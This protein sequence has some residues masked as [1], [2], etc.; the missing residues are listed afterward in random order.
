MDREAVDRIRASFESIAPRAPAV[1]KDFYRRLFEA[2]PDTKGLFPQDMARLE[3]HL[4]ASLATIAK[5]IDHLDVL[6]EPLM[7]LGA[8]H[9]RFGARPEHYPV[10]RDCLI[11]SLRECSGSAWSAELDK[12]WFVA[13]NRVCEAMLRG[14]LRAANQAAHSPGTINIRPQGPRNATSP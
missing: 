6:E 1:V 2:R 3:G 10:V 7:Q 11:A 14:V 12:D 9:I 5:N 4:L 13:L 8:E